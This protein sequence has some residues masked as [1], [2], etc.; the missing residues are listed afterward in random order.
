MSIPTSAERFTLAEVARITGGE[1]RGALE[2]ARPVYRFIRDPALIRSG[3]LFVALSE[4]P[5]RSL[6]RAAE[7][8]K[9]GAV[10]AL[11]DREPADDVPR[12]VVPSI[13][14][15]LRSLA[16][17]HRARC[18]AQVAAITGS[19]GK[20]TTK[21]LL[22]HLLSARRSGCTA[23]NF[24]GELG[25]PLTVLHE[26]DP[27]LD[28]FVAEI[29]AGVPGDVAR[30]AAM[31]SPRIAAVTAVAPAHLATLG[32]LEAVF[33]EKA[34]LVEALP[35]DGFLVLNG[36]DASAP[37]M[38]AL[39]G[40]RV[41]TVSLA[42]GPGSLS[43]DVQNAGLD[44]TRGR[45]A[46][47]G[48]TFDFHLPLVGSHLA[49]PALIALAIGRELGLAPGEMLAALRGLSPC[50]HRMELRR[51]RCL[52]LDD[53]YNANPLSTGAA[54]NLLAHA[55][56]DGRRVAVLGDMLELGAAS[57]IEHRRIVEWLSGAH[58]HAAFLVGPCYQEAGAHL[59]PDSR[60]RT[61]RDRAELA[62]ALA[63]A[64]QANDLVLLK[65]SRAMALEELLEPVFGCPIAP[66]PESQHV[67]RAPPEV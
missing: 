43:L 27:G 8:R 34:A 52:V 63:S 1:L 50:P 49:Y 17:A 48:E 9:N 64:I 40:G 66:A 26:L 35:S 3:D 51:G 32:D 28:S 20:T 18:R 55:P 42:R 39:F 6:S 36:D 54:L 2:P 62:P 46:W 31:L 12:V 29:G 23:A 45:L 21:E 59:R 37:R 19:C 57:T 14:A 33:R 4:G 60:V 61:F 16:A 25:L 56:H 44:G 58:I 13:P 7:A 41:A 65:G 38:R 10:A 67:Y 15:A 47:D 5:R 11:V 24:N 22:A 30:M 53:A